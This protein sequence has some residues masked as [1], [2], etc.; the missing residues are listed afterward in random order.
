MSCPLCNQSDS[1]YLTHE[2]SCWDKEACGQRSKT[3]EH[4]EMNELRDC[5]STDNE[6]MYVAL[7]R[8]MKITG[9]DHSNPIYE[10]CCESL[11]PSQR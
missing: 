6:Q 3:Y 11:P 5:F 1:N 4:A 8:I 7:K 9:H 2:G 10:I